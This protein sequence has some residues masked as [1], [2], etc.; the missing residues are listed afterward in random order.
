MAAPIANPMAHTDGSMTFDWIFFVIVV[1]PMV[2]AVWELYKTP[3]FAP[4]V[5]PKSAPRQRGR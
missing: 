5:A 1:I 3:K 2:L 4:Q